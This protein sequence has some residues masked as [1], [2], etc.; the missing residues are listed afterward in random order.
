ME[1]ILLIIIIIESNGNLFEIEI[2]QKIREFLFLFFS[3]SIQFEEFFCYLLR[4]RMI[5][6]MPRLAIRE[7]RPE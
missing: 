4:K 2:P 3:L 1:S 5:F 6:K 7:L